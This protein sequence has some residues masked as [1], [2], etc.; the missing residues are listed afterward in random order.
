M[1]T[2]RWGDDD[3]GLQRAARVLS[4]HARR[5]CVRTL[6]ME[7]YETGWSETSSSEDSAEEAEVTVS[8]EKDEHQEIVLS[9]VE[10]ELR[11]QQKALGENEAEKNHEE[12]HRKTQAAAAKEKMQ[13]DAGRDREKKESIDSAKAMAEANSEQMQHRSEKICTTTTQPLVA[14]T[15]IEDY[16]QS[17]TASST[18]KLRNEVLSS[19]N[20][21]GQVVKAIARG[22]VAS[23][24]AENA[25]QPASQRPSSSS[26]NANRQDLQQL[27]SSTKP[28]VAKRRVHIHVPSS[29]Q[30]SEVFASS[31]GKAIAPTRQT[32]PQLSPD[33]ALEL[34]Q[35]QLGPVV[36]QA[37]PIRSQFG[38]DSNGTF[39]QSPIRASD[40]GGV[41]TREQRRQTAVTVCGMRNRTGPD[42]FARAAS[43]GQVLQRRAHGR[44]DDQDIGRYACREECLSQTAHTITHIQIVSSV[45]SNNNCNLVA[46]HVRAPVKLAGSA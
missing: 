2:H 46:S 24:T 28:C 36:D 16:S 35:R 7:S 12:E 23:E 31:A 30:S 22:R 26:D 6:K 1:Y 25:N 21:P 10:N 5:S 41:Y 40:F 19:R 38:S 8:D 3:E 37:L 44:S 9:E 42:T 45:F 20:A 18:I 43:D 32:R 34:L 15:T 11:Q 14:R 33:E 4:A 13:R 39:H 17:G 29:A 27:A